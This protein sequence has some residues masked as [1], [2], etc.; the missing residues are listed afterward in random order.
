VGR[1]C[2]MG[3]DVPTVVSALEGCQ[4]DKNGGQNYQPSDER[5]SDIMLNL[6][7]DA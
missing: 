7:G 4:V 2:E 5:M 6:I 3:F 1:F